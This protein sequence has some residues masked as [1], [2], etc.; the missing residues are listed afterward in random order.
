MSLP[1]YKTDHIFLRGATGIVGS[2]LLKTLLEQTQSHI[3]CLVR[4]QEALEAESRVKKALNQFI[5][6]EGFILNE[7]QKRVSCISGDIQEPQLGIPEGLYQSL[8]KKIDLVIHAAGKIALFGSYSFFA[9]T[10][11]LGTSHLIDFSM[12]TTQRYFHY[13]SSYSIAGNTELQIPFTEFD[14][15]QGQTFLLKG[16]QQ[17]KF[18][19]EKIVRETEGLNWS[20]SRPGNILGESQTGNYP[21]DHASNTSIFYGLVKAFIQIQ[22]AF[23][24]HSL[25]DITPI[26]Y[27]GNALVFL[28]TK[29]CRTHLSYHLFNP[30]KC[31]H[32]HLARE[33]QS[34]GYDLQLYSMEQSV[35][36]LKKLM[37]S[38]KL[39]DKTFKLLAMA[40]LL[41]KNI[42]DMRIDASYTQSLLAP[43]GIVC[44]KVDT[45]L[46]GCYLQYCQRN[47]LIPPPPTPVS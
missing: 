43:F 28:L 7:F 18:N 3:Y 38:H 11:V 37:F 20:I 33:I 40:P 13:V 8:T 2:Y 21:I 31:T 45:T 46:I 23:Y 29:E 17:S 27:V 36:L 22:A 35:L 19:S 9:K 12:K 16:Y 47:G 1:Q 6:L 26:D 24:S 5:P 39:L 10:N 44:P 34:C 14:F 42:C 25:F 41:L 4:A 32:E 15:D 30:D